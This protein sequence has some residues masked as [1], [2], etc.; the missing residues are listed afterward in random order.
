MWS[1]INLLRLIIGLVTIGGV[2]WAALFVVEGVFRW[3]LHV[4]HEDLDG[5]DILSV[6]IEFSVHQMNMLVRG[7]HPFRLDFIP[8]LVNLPKGD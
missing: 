7:D 6:A 3:V 5:C 1:L 4:R 8:L 2:G